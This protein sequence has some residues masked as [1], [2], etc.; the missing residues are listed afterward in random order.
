[1]IEFCS[2]PKT[3][4]SPLVSFELIEALLQRI[5]VDQSVELPE[6]IA[7]PS[8][9]RGE[10]Y[11]KRLQQQR[12][13]FESEPLALLSDEE[14]ELRTPLVRQNLALLR[15]QTL[16]AVREGA[17]KALADLEICNADVVKALSDAL[18]SDPEWIV[19]EVAARAVGVLRVNELAMTLADTLSN[20]RWPS[21]R[22]EAAKSLAHLSTGVRMNESAIVSV[23]TNALSNDPSW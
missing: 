17:L 9:F 13:K 15:N 18:R 3:V 16:C 14:I 2:S 6:A 22:W 11:W 12:R 8:E 5:A 10:L 23:L 21:V 1:M 19:R 20:D 7:Y 4:S